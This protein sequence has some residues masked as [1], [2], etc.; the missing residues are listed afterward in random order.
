M[1]DEQATVYDPNTL[2]AVK[3]ILVGMLDA[4]GFEYSKVEVTEEE[5]LGSLRANIS[6]D[7]AAFIIGT[8]GERV[9]ALQYLL[10]SVL[11][12][13]LETKVFV[14]VDVDNY[15]KQRETRFIDLANEKVEAA[16]ATKYPQQ[17]PPLEPYLRRVVHLYLMKNPDTKDI[18]TCS[19]G[20]GENRHVVIKI[21]EEV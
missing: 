7:E 19:E 12:K 4:L 3:D 10:K 5:H 18:E 14:I 15:R 2:E 13:K 9:N 16:R 20:E 11:W 1:S 17:M 8:H 21:K 6:S